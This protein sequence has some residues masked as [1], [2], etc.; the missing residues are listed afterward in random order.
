MRLHNLKVSEGGVISL[1]GMKL[2]GVEAYVLATKAP[3]AAHIH[4]VLRVD[5]GS[6]P[7]ALPYEVANNATS[8]TLESVE[9]E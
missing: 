4:I 9:G 3:G 2:Q 7:Q 1:D 8:D 6:V 5:M